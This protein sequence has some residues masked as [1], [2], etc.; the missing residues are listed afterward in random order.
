MCPTELSVEEFE[1]ILTESSVEDKDLLKQWYQL[2]ENDL[3]PQYILQVGKFNTKL[4][5]NDL[6]YY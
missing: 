4:L 6:Y 1:M 2:D 3:P 5:L